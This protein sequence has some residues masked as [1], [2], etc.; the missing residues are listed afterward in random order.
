MQNPTANGP[1]WDYQARHLADD[2]NV[3]GP[4]DAAWMEKLTAM[5]AAAASAAATKAVQGSVLL[6]W[7]PQRSWMS[8]PLSL[9]QLRQQVCH[10]LRPED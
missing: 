5:A 4:A 1:Q 8:A 7:I 10:C 2:G 3:V 9:A 6:P